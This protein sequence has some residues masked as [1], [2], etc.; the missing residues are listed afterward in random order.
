M[1]SRK[2]PPMNDNPYPCTRCGLPSMACYG[3]LC[4]CT[5]CAKRDAQEIERDERRRLLLAVG[6]L[7]LVIWLMLYACMILLLPPF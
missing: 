7:C 4:L 2:G 3:P 6:A 5:W 1:S